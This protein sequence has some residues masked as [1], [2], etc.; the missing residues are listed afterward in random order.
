[1]KGKFSSTF[2]YMALSRNVLVVLIGAGIAFAVTT[3][4]YSPFTLT[5]VELV[6]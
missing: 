4:D 3:E 2:K 5:G 6:Y 1:M